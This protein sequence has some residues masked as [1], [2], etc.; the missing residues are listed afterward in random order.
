MVVRR[1]IKKEERKRGREVIFSR[2]VG[3]CRKKINSV[4]ETNVKNVQLNDNIQSAQ[5]ITT[6]NTNVDIIN[7]G[8]IQI[9][10]AEFLKPENLISSLKSGE[11][12]G[13]RIEKVLTELS[14][15][16]SI[17]IDTKLENIIEISKNLKNNEVILNIEDMYLKDGI[18]PMVLPLEIIETLSILQLM[19]ALRMV[20]VMIGGNFHMFT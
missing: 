14:K 15:N 10:I 19:R 18:E 7:V 20:M 1:E 16:A 9:D 17:N 2:N 5:D 6:Q 3:G 8:D 11:Y 4:N 13:I 12:N